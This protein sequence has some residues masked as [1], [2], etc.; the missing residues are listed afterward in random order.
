MLAT[1]SAPSSTWPLQ[2]SSTPLLQTS[3]DGP[4]APVH[5]PHARILISLVPV[6]TQACVPIVHAPTPASAALPTK[7]RCVVPS[8]HGHP[9]SMAPLASSSSPLPHVSRP[10]G[11]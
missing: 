9:S 3:A 1:Q 7:Q 11:D 8:T 2:S 5:G 6:A 4:R 10:L